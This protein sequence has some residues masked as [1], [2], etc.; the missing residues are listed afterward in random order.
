MPTCMYLMLMMIVYILIFRQRADFIGGAGAF[1]FGFLG[2]IW[3]R[4]FNGNSY[5]VTVP[6]KIIIFPPLL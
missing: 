4:V 3:A 2:N 1:V 5:V 6:R